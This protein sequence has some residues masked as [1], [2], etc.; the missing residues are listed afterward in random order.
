VSFSPTG[1]IFEPGDIISFSL[2][3]GEVDGSGGVTFENKAISLY[4]DDDDGVY[5]G[6]WAVPPAFSLKDAPV[7]GDFVDAAGNA[8]EQKTCP[9]LLNINTRPEAVELL[10]AR[11]G[12]DTS[13]ATLYWTESNDDN[14][15]SYRL[16]VS[17][18][19]STSSIPGQDDLVAYLSVKANTEHLFEAAEAAVHNFRVFVFDEHGEWAASNNV[20]ISLGP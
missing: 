18:G 15:E 11:S 2:D 12:Q 8:A 6:S 17:T 10:V 7:N 9:D 20:S 1:V 4:D 19:G 16:Y 3:A 5:T 13:Q 14:F